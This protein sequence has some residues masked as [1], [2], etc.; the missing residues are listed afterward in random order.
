M[1]EGSRP[2]DTGVIPFKFILRKMQAQQPELGALGHN[3]VYV[4][5]NT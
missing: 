2:W 5:M 3:A 1:R 4:N